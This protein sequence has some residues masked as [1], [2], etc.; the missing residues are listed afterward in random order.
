MLNKKIEFVGLLNEKDY[1][2]FSAHSVSPKVLLPV[3]W[4][5]T[6]CQDEILALQEQ[7]IKI[8]KHL[9]A[10]KVSG[11]TGSQETPAKRNRIQSKLNILGY[12]AFG[13]FK[14]GVCIFPCNRTKINVLCSTY[15]YVM[16]LELQGIYCYACV[17]IFYLVT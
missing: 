1:S 6:V 12:N 8:Q 2:S 17:I 10:P 7:V 16:T 13:I 14:R 15:M 5:T 9:P 4:R 3:V 11:P